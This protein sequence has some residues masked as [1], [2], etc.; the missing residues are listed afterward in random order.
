MQDLLVNPR[1]KDKIITLKDY[2]KLSKPFEFILYGDNILEGISLLNNLTLNDDLLAFYGVVYE[3]Y[4]SPIYI[5]RESDHFYAI[6]ICGHYDKWNLPND[7]SFIKSFVDLPDYI[8]Y[9][10]QH[11]KVI[12][13]GENTETASVGNSQWQREGR[14]IAA[15]K[16]RVP[17]IYQT[18][19][20]GKDESLDTIREPNALQAYNAILY[21]ARYKSPNLIAYFE[22]NFHGST[23]RIRNPIDSQELFIK[24]IKS[25]LLSS[26]NP[27]FLNTKIKLEKEFFMHI[28]NYLKE[29]KY[30]DKKRIVSNEP[31]IISDLP[32]MTNSIRQGILRD[33]ENFVNS[34]MDYIY[35]NNDDFMA[36]F[37][38]SSFDFDKL[39]EWTFYKSYQY[40]GNLLTFLKLN[41]NAAKSYISRAKIG[42]V[43]S[44][45]TAKFLGDKFRH[46]KAEIESI[47]ISKSSLLLPL[48]I[49]KNSNGKLTLSPDPESGEIV[50][51]SELFG[52]GLDGQKRYKIIGYCFVDTPSDFDF[53]K[54]MDTKI[55]KA[56]ANYID[57]LILNDKEVITSF[58][59]SLPIQNNYY[60]CNLNIA[61]KNI[62]EEVAI[63]STYLNQS[64]IKAGWNLCF[65]SLIV[66]TN[67]DK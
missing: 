10:I 59:I 36:Q 66:A 25:V 62:N 27:Q 22:N 65:T 19:Y 24:Y 53:A 47:L 48:R 4:D 43:D 52:Y 55:Y 44:K 33:S 56:L 64:T 28:I 57:I 2:E 8:F 63:V 20:S 16:L 21:S 11:S 5:F 12:L 58:E 40:L 14:K 60:P 29:G 26:V 6:K 42:F 18:F 32:I 37:D 41:N 13:A 50:A 61:P 31:R 7:V 39:K 1:I 46:K 3:P 38:V 67:N 23:T 17:F 49:H 35:N 54:K 34:L 30:S 51:Y 9:S 45:L 15:A